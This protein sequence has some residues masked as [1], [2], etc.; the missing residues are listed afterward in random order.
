MQ[1]PIPSP[2]FWGTKILTTILTSDILPY[3]HLE[4]LYHFHWGFARHDKA[5]AET[6]LQQLIKEDQENSIIQP[7]ASYGYFACQSHL[8]DLLIYNTPIAQQKLCH[9]SFP[10]QK[11]GQQLC[12]A[13]FFRA[14]EDQECDIIALQLATIGTKAGNFARILFENN[15]YQKYLFWRGFNV[16]I[17]DAFAELIHR[18]IRLELEFTTEKTLTISDI[19]K[20]KYQ[21]CRFSLGFPACP[22]LEDQKKIVELLDA[23]KLGIKLSETFQ[24]IPEESTSALIVH[25]PN[26]KHFII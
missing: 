24:L 9:F 13:D 7:Q 21:G 3:M 12:L 6:V 1:V 19:L 14:T 10:R 18:K 11:T 15:E 5:L 17:T 26:C 8:N 4:S 2:P 22:N 16:V 25:H 20:H 23:Q